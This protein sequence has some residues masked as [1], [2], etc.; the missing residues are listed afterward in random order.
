M[1]AKPLAAGVVYELAPDKFL[2]AGMMS[3]LTF[4]VKEGENL[5]VDYLKLEEGRV[6]KGQWKPGRIL[7]GDEK[8]S[9]RLGDMPTCLYV[10]LYRY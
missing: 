8:M 4:R 3:S 6:E 1:P 5:K 10:E 2:I 9:L 7:K